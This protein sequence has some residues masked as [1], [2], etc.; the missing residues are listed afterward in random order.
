MTVGVRL[1]GT[2]AV[3]TNGRH[4]VLGGAKQRLVLAG[5]ALAAGKPLSTD[6]IV[7]LLWDDA[8]PVSA[9]RTVQSYVASLRS[10]LGSDGPL[11]RSGAGYVLAVDRSRVDMLRFEDEVS[12]VL[13]DASSDPQSA[14]FRLAEVLSVW[15]E[16][17]AGTTLSEGFRSVLAPFEELHLQAVE[18]LWVARIDSGDAGVAVRELESLVRKHPTREHLWL[19]LAR[20]LAVLGRRS[21]ALQALQRAR[22]ALREQLGI[23][24]GIHLQMLEQ[25][26]LDGHEAASFTPATEQRSAVGELELPTG[27][28]PWP[29]RSTE[30][31]GRAAQLDE[32]HVA[33]ADAPLIT[34]FGVGGVGKTRLA[35]ELAVTASADF[36][37]GCVIVE[38]AGVTNPDAVAATVAASVGAVQSN[39]RPL[40]AV[41]DWLR[42]KNMLVMLDNCEHVIDAAAEVVARLGAT[43]P[44]VSLLT[45]SREPIGVDGERVWR[46]PA[47]NPHSDGLE[48][49]CLR[50]VA[51]DS[52]FDLSD[53]ERA[54]IVSICERLDGNPLAIELAAA[55]TRSMGVGDL[56][57]HLDDRLRLLRG[58][59]RGAQR[60]QTLR[61]MVEWSYR[62]LDDTE[63][64]FFAALSVFAGGFDLV[65][66]ENIGGVI[67]SDADAAVMLGELVD[68]S[69]VEVDRTHNHGRYRVLETLR[70]FGAEQLDE[71]SEHT[72]VRDAH[73]RHYVDVA[74]RARGRF[75][76]EDWDGGRAVYVVE[77]DNL[78][79]ALDRALATRDLTTATRL[80]ELTA[81]FGTIQ[82]RHDHQDW[83]NDVLDLASTVGRPRPP[84]AV[85]GCKA[86]WLGTTVR[87]P[88]ESQRLAFSGIE[89]APTPA[90]P[91]TC[92]CWFALSMPGSGSVLD[93]QS[94]EH[95]DKAS[96]ASS[97]QFDR[98]LFAW[99]LL[100]PRAAGNDSAKGAARSVAMLE[101]LA[102]G[103][104]NPAPGIWL[105]SARGV[106]ARIAGDF[107]AALG[108]YERTISDAQ[109][110][111]HHIMVATTALFMA[112]ALARR[113]GPVDRA[114]YGRAIG[115]TREYRK[116]EAPT[117][118]L[119]ATHL[120]RN[121]HVEQGST[122]HGFV[123]A[124]KAPAPGVPWPDLPDVPEARAWS[125]T[126]AAMIL[127]E[128]AE[129]ALE[130]LADLPP[131]P[132]IRSTGRGGR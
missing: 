43:C 121:G 110:I 115:L 28:V 61:A 107:D 60:H 122:L 53:D 25:A 71:G 47:L 3:D 73:M 9:R 130:A 24:P 125:V 102:A 38:L 13:A 88:E 80:V 1:L 54:T 29:I 118:A 117:I 6:R 48:L 63:Q 11:S 44:R 109:A 89:A 20:G 105:A 58:G 8:P 65:A 23:D 91:S 114:A 35:T 96:A 92:W 39:L 106:A 12:D 55:R 124:A 85:A 100:L 84:P 62:L 41:T 51:A 18:A 42:D 16:P 59:R 36:D 46:V 10:A 50:A 66:A 17:L 14:A 108:H 27:T 131:D 123:T 4:V 40:E 82:V 99:S 31:V 49:F 101:Q 22:E 97:D 111:G 86:W 56:A 119:F 98:C 87:F 70:Q 90:D 72:V 76:G 79:R 2:V 26:L 75:T 30:L 5:L 32:L 95:W 128:A 74:E 132:R 33:L 45:T 126:G 34:L 37:D 69:M 64:R 67:D 21:D 83:V 127:D 113:G 112:S 15:A 93:R 52:S 116:F 94:L 68:K 104:A 78:R 77:W 7:E 129:Y 81:R 120:L 103:T 19:Q 57:D